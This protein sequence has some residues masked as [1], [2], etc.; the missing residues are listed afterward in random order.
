MSF[1]LHLPPAFPQLQSGF[2]AA[3]F[4][5]SIIL[6]VSTEIEYSVLCE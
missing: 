6:L 3:K 2:L 5:F 4:W 1:L